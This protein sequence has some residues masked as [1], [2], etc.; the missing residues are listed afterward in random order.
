MKGKRGEGIKKNTH[1]KREK[2]GREIMKEKRDRKDK[3]GT[4]CY[5]GENF[6]CQQ[7]HSQSK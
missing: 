6:N 5:K 1:T 7:L 3:A 2:V 4:A